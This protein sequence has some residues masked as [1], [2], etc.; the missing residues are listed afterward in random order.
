MFLNLYLAALFHNAQH[1][2]SVRDLLVLGAYV[3]YFFFLLKIAHTT[4]IHMHTSNSVSAQSKRA[5]TI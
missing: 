3:I 1:Q 4:H 5:R 2:M